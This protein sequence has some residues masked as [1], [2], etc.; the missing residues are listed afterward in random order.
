MENHDQ[1][2]RSRVI[3]NII[4]L[5]AGSAIS[6]GLTSLT[7]LAT[8]RLLGP[9]SYGQYTATLTLATFAS[10][11]FNLGLNTWGMHEA[12]RNPGQARWILGSLLSVKLVV[13]MLWCGIMFLLASLV[14]GDT[15]PADLL[16]LNVLVVWV[17]SMFSSVLLPLKV[18]LRNQLTSAFMV[19]SDLLWMSATLVLVYIGITEPQVYIE[20]RLYVLVISLL[21]AAPW[22]IRIYQLRPRLEIVLSALRGSFPYASSEI[23]LVSMK[24]ID[25]LLVALMLG[26]QAIGIY[27][28]AVSIVNALLLLLDSAS[29]VM[30][31]VL[32][33]SFAQRFSQG[34]WEARRFVLLQAVFGLALL[35]LLWAG[36]GLI[37]LLLGEGY[38]ASIDILKILSPILVIHAFV[39]AG[40]S[41]YTSTNQQSRRSAIQAVAVVLNV[42]F[43]IL[44]IQLFGITGAA[45]VYVLTELFLALVFTSGVL[46][47]Q[48]SQAS[49]GVST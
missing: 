2:G 12:S 43:N 31:P 33:R 6:Q 24:R 34:W 36:M 22:I 21:L 42:V 9:Q 13:G 26:S 5:L 28:P 32:S 41:I 25:V 3:T 45:V 15:F 10:I 48:R 11:L 14:D 4:Y 18:N 17:D 29:N 7:L 35:V 44:A 23:L 38:S 1:A 40:A 49:S 27:A 47:F 16:R 20:Y 46:Q 19:L 39:T 37:G 30:I 8:A